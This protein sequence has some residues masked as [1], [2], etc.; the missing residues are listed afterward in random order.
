[1]IQIEFSE[2]EREALHYERYHHPHPRVQ[3][4]MEVLWLKSINYSHKEIMKIAKISKATLC[5]YLK[6]FEEGGIDKLKELNFYKP[7]SELDEHTKTIEE[8]FEK[9]PPASIKESMAKIEEL[10]GIKRGETQIRVFLKK[11]GLKYRKVGML[12]SKADVDEQERFKKK[13]WNQFWK[14]LKKENVLF[15]LLMP[16]ILFLPLI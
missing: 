6:D 15:I 11:I 14:K 7:K 2:E 4:K 1:M 5:C 9:H 8:Y 13:N 16:L 3:K 12:P 10:T